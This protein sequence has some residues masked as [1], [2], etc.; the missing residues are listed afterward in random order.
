MQRPERRREGELG[1]NGQRPGGAPASA[2]R[3]SSRAV[4]A[5][6]EPSAA[7]GARVTLNQ[8]TAPPRVSITE[9][10]QAAD[11]HRLAAPRHV[12]ELVATRPPMVSK[13]S[14][15]STRA[16]RLVD[17]VDLD[18]AGDALAAVG[19]RV[20]AGLAVLV[21]ELVLDLADDLLEHVLDRDQAGGRCR[22]RRSRSRGGCGW[23]GSRAAARSGPST[24]ARTPP[25]AASVRRFRS[26]ERC[27]FSRSFAIRMPMTLSRCPRRPG[28]AS[29]RCRSR[30]AAGRRSRRVDVEQVHARCGDHHVAGGHAR[31]C[32]SRPR[33]SSATR[34]RS[35]P[36]ARRRPATR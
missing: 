30:C 7:S 27:S 5:P 16:E 17:G 32:G 21:V 29:A 19:E 23:S 34:A 33:A 36:S 8:R 26:G 25:G 12:A 20:D 6:S 2:R 3:R 24:R 13:S 28:S 18:V 22:T 10:T 31:P 35:A 15:G 9:K 1:A 11:R 4:Q 14:V